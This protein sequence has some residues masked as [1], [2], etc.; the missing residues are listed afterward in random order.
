MANTGNVA[1]WA[2]STTAET[3]R[4]RSQAT[5]GNAS[6]QSQAPAKP[7]VSG[8]TRNDNGALTRPFTAPVTEICG[9]SKRSGVTGGSRSLSPTEPSPP[10][11]LG[12]S[13]SLSTG[14]VGSGSSG[15]VAVVGGPVVG[16]AEVS[17]VTVVDVVVD[18]LG[19]VVVVVDVEVVVVADVVVGGPPVVDGA[20]TTT[21]KNSVSNNWGEPLSST[22]TVTPNVPTPVEVQKNS[23]VVG[24]M[25]AP[26]G[27]ETSDHVR[28]SGGALGS[29]ATKFRTTDWP[30][31][32]KSVGTSTLR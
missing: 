15:V 25:V 3:P 14:S 5:S 8:G 24:L 1:P 21:L 20:E 10:G 18:V 31:V 2:T 13:T 27:A 30:M 9:D 6:S 23:P 32:L 29:A 4:R 12:P 22:R 28:T 17:D 16:G 26:A 11:P 7:R 19:A